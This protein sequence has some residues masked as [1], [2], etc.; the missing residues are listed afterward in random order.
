MQGRSYGF[1]FK[2]MD[3]DGDDGI[4]FEDILTLRH[5]KRGWDKKEPHLS[6][7]DALWLELC[8]LCQVSTTDMI[9]LKKMKESQ[10]GPFCFQ[11]F[12]LGDE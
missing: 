3:V 7:F 8:D 6:K 2:V 1:W 12:I 11:H 5:E 4:S 9:P 10:A